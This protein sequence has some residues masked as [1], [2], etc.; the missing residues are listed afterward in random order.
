MWIIFLKGYCV[1][2]RVEII[3]RSQFK[4]STSNF[5]GIS[6]STRIKKARLR[7]SPFQEHSDF[8]VK[9]SV[10]YLNYYLCKQ[11]KARQGKAK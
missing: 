5:T 4:H 2:V 9:S 11:S 7:G 3:L 10:S 8:E 1:L 6:K